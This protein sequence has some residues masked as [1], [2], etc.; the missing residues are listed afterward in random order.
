M[1]ASPM[2]VIERFAATLRDAGIRPR[3]GAIGARRSA[4]LAGSSPRSAPGTAVPA[5]A[6]RRERLEAESAAALRGER[7]HDPVPAGVGE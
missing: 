5:V 1:A 7:S 2:P 3:S 6:R 4:R